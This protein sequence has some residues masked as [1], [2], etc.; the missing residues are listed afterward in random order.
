MAGRRPLVRRRSG[1]AGPP[2]AVRES[3]GVLRLRAPLAG[4]GAGCPRDPICGGRVPP[5]T[6]VSDVHPS[7]RQVSRSSS[8]A[9]T[10]ALASGATSVSSSVLR[11]DSTLPETPRPSALHCTEPRSPSCFSVSTTGRTA[12][13]P[14]RCGVPLPASRRRSVRPRDPAR[15]RSTMRNRPQA[16]RDESAVLTTP[17]SLD[18]GPAC[19]SRARDVCRPAPAGTS[20]RRAGRTARRR[21]RRVPPCRRGPR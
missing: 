8:T 4:L 1:C 7:P 10:N 17:A 9:S 13:R 19:P 3:E 14:R 15:G 2:D 21:S 16:N 5:S 6:G 11:T 20:C 18:P 12:S